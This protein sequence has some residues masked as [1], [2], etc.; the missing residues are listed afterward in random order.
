M[1]MKTHIATKRP[2]GRPPSGTIG[3]PVVVRLPPAQV[4]ALDEVAEARLAS[5]AQIARERIGAPDDIRRGGG[6]REV[7]P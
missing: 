7:T 3:L 2:V 4:D 5:R 1:A 6:L